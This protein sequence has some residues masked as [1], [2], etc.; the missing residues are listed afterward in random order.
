MN[1]T[2]PQGERA[3]AVDARLAE[4]TEAHQAA[5]VDED[6]AEADRLLGQVGQRVSELIHER[7]ERGDWSEDFLLSV[8]AMDCE[9]RG[10]WDSALAAYQKSLR[11]AQQGSV[12]FA[13]SRAHDDLADLYY[14]LGD[15]E[16][17]L[18]EQQ[19][20]T[21]AARN[22]DMPL[23][24]R[25]A[26]EG[27]AR[28]LLRLGRVTEAAARVLEAL[29]L[30][31]VEKVEE[32][33]VARLRILQARCEAEFGH[34]VEA[35]EIL[36]RVEFIARRV[37]QMPNATGYQSALCSWWWVEAM[38]CDIE[39]DINGQIDSLRQALS[40]A[41]RIAVNPPCGVVY[42]ASQVLQI[43]DRLGEALWHHGDFDE[44]RRLR[45]ESQELRA[46]LKLPVAAS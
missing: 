45:R 34:I 13:V 28:L 43:L 6:F 27:E 38:C 5:M 10:D 22:D 44:A 23:V 19:L 15:Q 26:L 42:S 17:A 1:E 35:R 33:G 24:L 21:A 41:R 37:E 40:L 2:E 14:L 4:L 11:L 9:Q 29:K 39:D 46:S 25:M 16:S 31:N 12:P 8:E 7:A 18:R 32:L 20:A 30:P 36:R 3:D